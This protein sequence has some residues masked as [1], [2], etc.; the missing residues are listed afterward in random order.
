MRKIVTMLQH[1]GQ[2]KVT[3]YLLSRFFGFCTGFC[4]E[5]SYPDGSDTGEDGNQ[6]CSQPKGACFALWFCLTLF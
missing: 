5:C 3:N 1:P 6:E 2:G 4:H